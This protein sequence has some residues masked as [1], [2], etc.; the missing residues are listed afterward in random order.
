MKTITESIAAIT[1]DFM[2]AIA[3]ELEYEA[4]CDCAGD[5]GYDDDETEE[6]D[7]EDED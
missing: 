4:T 6:E 1:P 2:S 7:E 5:Y 3:S